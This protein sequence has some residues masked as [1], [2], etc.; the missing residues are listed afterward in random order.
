MATSFRIDKF[1]FLIE[2]SY[3]SIRKN[4]FAYWK[5]NFLIENFIL[6]IENLNSSVRLSKLRVINVNTH[7]LLDE[8]AR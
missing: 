4:Y 6:L 2:S 5:K 1:N 8:R 3:F 7:N